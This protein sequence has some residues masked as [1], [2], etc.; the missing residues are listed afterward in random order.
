MNIDIPLPGI[1]IDSCLQDLHHI[2]SILFLT[3][4]SHRAYFC[5]LSLESLSF[6]YFGVYSHQIWA[7]VFSKTNTLYNTHSTKNVY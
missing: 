7:T 1:S 2:Q 5:S 4:N 6:V 3:V